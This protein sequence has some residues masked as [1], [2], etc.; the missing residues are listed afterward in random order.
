[1][2]Q[3]DNDDDDDDDDDDNDDAEHV[4]RY[5]GYQLLSLFT[6]CR[7]LLRDRASSRESIGRD[8]STTT[9]ALSAATTHCVASSLIPSLTA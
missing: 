7:R 9:I 8:S 4:C 2:S 6:S 5:H 1:V 3:C